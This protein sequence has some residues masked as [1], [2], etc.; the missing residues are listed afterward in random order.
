MSNEYVPK[1]CPITRTEFRAARKQ[2][3]IMIDGRQF[4]ALMKQFKTGS[5]GWYHSGKLPIDLGDGQS[6]I[7]CQ[8]SVMVTVIGSKNVPA[9]LFTSGILPTSD[10]PGSRSL[11]LDGLTPEVSRFPTSDFLQAPRSADKTHETPTSAQN[12]SESKPG[13][14]NGKVRKRT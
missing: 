10:S 1:D 8:I 6:N 9:D 7:P 3:P 14:G 4:F 12:A 13:S 11:D 5:F 2:L